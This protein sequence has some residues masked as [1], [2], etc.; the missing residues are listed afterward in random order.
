LI[1]SY[2]GTIPR[3]YFFV[4]SL[5]AVKT[6]QEWQVS[7]YQLV[8]C[9]FAPWPME[10]SSWEQAFFFMSLCMAFALRPTGLAQLFHALKSQKRHELGSFSL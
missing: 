2:R 8:K 9:K 10:G 7:H 5:I 4:N 6:E 1:V 3:I